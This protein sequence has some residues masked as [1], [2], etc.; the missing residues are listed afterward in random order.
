[1]NTI[2]AKDPFEGL[3]VILTSMPIDTKNHVLSRNF[4]LYYAVYF[5]SNSLFTLPIYFL[6]GKEYLGL[7][8]FLAG[9]FYVVS[10]I[11]MI[12]LDF[13]GGLTADK[14]G[15]KRAFTYGVLFQ[16][17]GFVPFLLTKSYPVLL[18]GAAATGVGLALAQNSVDALVYEQA[19]ELKQTKQFNVASSNAQMFLF[20]GRIMASVLGGLAYKLNPRLPFG[21]NIVA[22]VI[23]LI[24]GA[25][26]VFDETTL[27]KQAKQNS[28]M[29]LMKSAF[30]LYKENLHLLK[31]VIVSLFFYLWADMLFLYYQPYFI[32]LGVQASTLGYIFAAISVFSAIGSVMMR[33]LPDKFSATAIQSLTLLGVITSSFLLIIL[34]V[35]LAFAAP[36]FMGII[37]GFNQPLLRLYVNQ[38]ATNH[39]RASVLSVATTA[40]N[41]GTGLGFLAA[42]ALADYVKATV[43]LSIIL[44]GAILTLSVKTIVHPKSPIV[45]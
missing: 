34:K 30:T 37:S 39:V 2:V 10:F 29:A 32:N 19:L 6:F 3:F 21:L 36:M 5:F 8:Y 44:V 15:R 40:G 11:V 45:T 13:W 27:K 23:A 17:A 26:M 20:V 28:H 1:V 16:I 43:V 9:S 24:A 18:L 7:S 41:I 14:F 4:L 38:Q 35:P 42:I 12:G 31:F 33:R 22:L 25:S